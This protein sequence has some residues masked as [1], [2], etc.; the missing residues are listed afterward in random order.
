[1]N[2]WALI[3]LLG[4]IA[5]IVFF[6]R[7]GLAYRFLWKVQQDSLI[8]FGKRG[9]GK[10]LLFSVLARQ[11][12]KRSKAKAYA[13]NTDFQHKGGEIIDPVA[14]NVSP[15]TWEG[16][17]NGE[18][19]PTEDRGFEG[20]A[21]YL[22]DAGIYLP[23]FADSLL[24][25]NYPSMPIALAVWRHLYNAPIHINSQDVGR[26]WKMVREQ[27]DGFLKARSVM[28]IGPFFRLKLTYFDKFAS[29]DKDLCPIKKRL[30]RGKGDSDL[31][32]AE[33][34]FIK[35]FAIW[36]ICRH[37]KYDSRY[38]RQL[39]FRSEIPEIVANENGEFMGIESQEET[40][41]E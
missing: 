13:S 19:V 9:H 12:A 32:N 1:M 25:K 3:A 14:V 33:N 8:V 16:V 15:N 24:K 26:C 22:D 39:F 28:K 35:D 2:V 7:L 40:T 17:L 4:L 5:L 31:Y 21:L 11:W 10:S 6:V 36:G 23:N 30:L 38:F 37:H 34:G 29:A 18:I 41:K 27:A 20:K